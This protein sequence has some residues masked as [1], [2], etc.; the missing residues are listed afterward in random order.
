MLGPESIIVQSSRE[1]SRAAHHRTIAAIVGVAAFVLVVTAGTQIF[2][3]TFYAMSNA[4]SILAGDRIYRD[5][6]EPGVPM[7]SYAAALAQL[8]SGHRLI[9]EFVRQW[10]FILA[11]VGIAA[12]LGVRASRSTRATLAAMTVALPILAVT[13]IY[14]HDKLFFFPLMLWVGWR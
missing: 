9:G 8:L 14:H 2:D 11:G 1:L 4:V 7:A 13:P 12:H 5:F 3:A 10:L 6:F